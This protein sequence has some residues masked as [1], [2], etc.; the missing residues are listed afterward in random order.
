VGVAAHAACPSGP[1]A[2]TASTA[3]NTSAAPRRAHV[4]VCVFTR[5]AR[6]SVWASPAGFAVFLRVRRDPLFINNSTSHLRG[7]APAGIS[8]IFH[9]TCNILSNCAI[10]TQ[11]KLWHIY[12]V[13]L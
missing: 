4:P 13:I 11:K 8:H 6:S 5:T 3:L 7:Q 1:A 12:M 10:L 2:A 9:F